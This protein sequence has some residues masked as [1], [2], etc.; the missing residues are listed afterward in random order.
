MQ[1]IRPVRNMNC[2][3]DLCVCEGECC[4][5]SAEIFSGNMHIRLCIPVLRNYLISVCSTAALNFE[6]MIQNR[7]HLQI[8]LPLRAPLEAYTGYSS[9]SC[10]IHRRQL[11]QHRPQSAD[12]RRTDLVCRARFDCISTTFWSQ[13][14]NY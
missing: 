13:S 9:G 5:F 2:Q 1:K 11:L 10:T 4:I 6:R 12:L 14:P 7:F 3:S 8:H